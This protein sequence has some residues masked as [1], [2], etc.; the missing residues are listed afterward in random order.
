MCTRPWL[1][2]FQY[3]VP[4]SY[5]YWRWHQDT[6]HYLQRECLVCLVVV[7]RQGLQ[8]FQSNRLPEFSLHWSLCSSAHT[9]ISLHW[10][11]NAVCREHKVRVSLSRTYRY[12]PR[13][14]QDEFQVPQGHHSHIESLCPVDPRDTAS[15]RTQQETTFLAAMILQ[16]HSH[17]DGPHRKCR[18]Q[19][20]FYCSVNICC[21]ADVT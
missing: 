20:F 3:G 14:E 17:S 2:S 15:G 21:Y 18:V 13:T 1:Q 6:L 5:Y 7:H 4:M 9:M 16:S 11:S 8:V 12:R 19:Q 10:G